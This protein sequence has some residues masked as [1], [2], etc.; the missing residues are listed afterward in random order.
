MSYQARLFIL[1]VGLI[2][3]NT[4]CFGQ[5]HPV[6]SNNLWGL[7]NNKGVLVVP[8]QYEAISEFKESGK[9]IAQKNGKMGLIDASGHLVIECKYD[10]LNI[11]G[12]DLYYIR[13]NDHWNVINQR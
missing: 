12:E 3:L 1:F 8:F 13:Q 4:T 7:I 2:Q 9:A 6:K 5:L 11:I 10:F